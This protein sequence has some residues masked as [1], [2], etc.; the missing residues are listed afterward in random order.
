MIP[1]I[2]PLIAR[3]SQ[4]RVG[5]HEAV[6]WGGAGPV[7]VMIRDGRGGAAGAPGEVTQSFASEELSE[8][9]GRDVK[10]AGDV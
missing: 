4:P 8:V 7:E 9:S 10:V 1:V 2:L 5:G 3:P 6:A